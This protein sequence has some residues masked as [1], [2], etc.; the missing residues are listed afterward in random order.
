MEQQLEH[1]QPECSAD[2]ID[3]PDFQSRIITSL[4]FPLIVMIVLFHLYQPGAKVDDSSAL[5]YTL[6]KLLGADGIA[7]IAVLAFFLI[8]GYLFF[9]NVKR[10]DRNTY[11]KKLRSRYT[12]LLRPYLL[13][14]AMPIIL[15]VILGIILAAINGLPLF[16]K[17]REFLDSIGWFNAFW[18]VSD[19]HPYVVPL[20]YVRDLMICCLI[21]PLIYFI[22]CS[23]AGIVYLLMIGACYLCDFW[24]DIPGLC[25]RA[26]FFFSV[27][28]FFSIKRMNMV[29]IFSKIQMPVY[30]ITL[31]LLVTTT[32]V[33]EIFGPYHLFACNVFIIFGIWSLFNIASYIKINF[34]I[35]MPVI[36]TDSVFF[37][38]AFHVFPLPEI[39]SVL[40]GVQSAINKILMQDNPLLRL[41]E[42]IAAPVI[43][44][45]ICI[46]AFRLFSIIA[47]RLCNVMNGN[48]TLYK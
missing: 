5:Y 14:N 8:S 16:T 6:V 39:G 44:V 10:L 11:Y 45:L 34:S 4:R 23:Q 17:A 38:F 41:I 37:I 22:L 31:L 32:L 3:H 46:L 30:I 26:L 28:A 35:E 13:W 33:P 12:T 48:R 21:T 24:F 7:K 42:I 29:L 25:I 20:W 40:A 27:G 18:N 43:I 2:S 36:L 19:G 15:G 1:R 47:P 9:Y